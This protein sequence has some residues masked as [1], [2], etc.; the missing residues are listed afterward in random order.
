[1][2]YNITNESNQ[3]VAVSR[4]F[5]VIP[6]NDAPVLA[7]IQRSLNEDTQLK[8]TVD[9]N[10]ITD[11]DDTLHQISITNSPAHGKLI[12]IFRNQLTY[13]PNQNF[14]GT[15]SFKIRV[16][17]SMALSNENTVFIKINPVEDRPIAIKSLFYQVIKG[18]NLNVKYEDLLT[19]VID[20]DGDTLKVIDLID[21]ENDLLVTKGIK[22]YIISSKYLNLGVIKK[23]V[24]ITDSNT[25]PIE[26]NFI[27]RVFPEPK[28]SNFESIK[29]YPNP[30]SSNFTIDDLQIGLV[31][32]YSTTGRLFFEKKL[33]ESI[34][35]NLINIT[36][37]AKGTYR[38]VLYHNNEV[39]AIKTLI[40]I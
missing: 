29:I 28:Q 31:R 19:A 8:L 39:I 9:Q 4:I 21:T 26:V 17:D 38:V 16:K 14:Y 15:D 33:D 11:P 13:E 34:K 37:I 25:D 1:L 7:S 30:T 35:T 12:S 32:I 18:N 10:Y 5:Y 27:L 3:M 2:H 23:K 20:H 6:V 40:V 24:T 22:E 36:N